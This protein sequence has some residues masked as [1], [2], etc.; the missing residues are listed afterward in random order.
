[1]ST[2]PKLDWPNVL[3]HRTQRQHLAAR[4]PREELTA[5]VARVGGLHA[6]V[7]SAAE[8]AAW[9]RLDGLAQGELEGELWEHRRLVKTWAMRGTLHL[10]PAVEYRHWQAALNSYDHYLK[11]AWFRGF[12][13]T[14]EEL[15]L[16]LECVMRALG[17][18]GLTRDQL[19]QAVTAASGSEA[20]GEKLR[21]S[22]GAYLKPASFRGHLCFGPNQGQNVTFV[23]P[24]DWLAGSEEVD[25]EA[26]LETVTRRYL[27]AYGP[28]TTA[29]YGR[30]W[31]PAQP[32]PNGAPPARPRPRGHGSGP[33]GR[34]ALG[35]RR[36]C[37]HDRADQ[38][39]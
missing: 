28:A 11:P 9:A 20:L 7:L 24:R 4:R 2:L 29:E 38:A 23:S 27:A 1:M 18:K 15:D 16:L 34:A 26:A 10:L 12:D 19:A 25:P 33:R 8:L 36:G 17:A 21:N 3:A 14:R 35:A 5:V 37:R 32:A 13:I 6:Q 39:R 22:W 30:W 31:G